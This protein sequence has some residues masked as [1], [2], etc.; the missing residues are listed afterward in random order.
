MAPT[1]PLHHC[2]VGANAARI[3]K[4][5]AYVNPEKFA[6][7]GWSFGGFLTLKTLESYP[8]VFPYGLAV[9]PVTDWRFYDSIYTER[10]ML[11][12]AANPSGYREAAITNT[13]ALSLANRFFIAHGT[14]DDNVH[15]QNTFVLLDR[16]TGAGVGNYDVCTY[17]DDD[18]SIFFH[19][20]HRALYIRMTEWLE[21][22]FGR[23]EPGGQVWQVDGELL[24][25]KE[26]VDQ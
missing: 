2:L 19:G 16:L 24:G 3:W 26:G 4:A 1:P 22:W 7:W 20:G 13:S 11:T 21:R 5:K 15:T 25:F 6:I 23:K 18:H 14:G 17:V 10:Y 12:P 9:A 8:G